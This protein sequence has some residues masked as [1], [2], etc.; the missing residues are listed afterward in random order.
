MGSNPRKKKNRGFTLI[1]LLVVIA[2][3]GVLSSIG[4]FYMNQ[5][6][7]KAYDAETIAQLSIARNNAQLFFETFGDYKG[8]G[9]NAVANRCDANNSM[10]V[11]TQ[12]GMINYTT[13]SNYP[14]STSL[15]CSSNPNAYQMSAS[16]SA[17]GEYW[18]VNSQGLSKRIYGGNHAD[19]HPNN[20]TDC[21]P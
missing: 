11:D 21:M 19:A 1:E 14:P 10:F 18:C 8:N 16:L 15:R 17:S 2:I 12:S 9:P 6:R 20:D 4:L 13:L 5:G 3:I 7:K